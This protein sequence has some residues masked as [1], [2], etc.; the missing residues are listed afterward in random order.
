MGEEEYLDRLQSDT[1]PRT[2]Y[3]TMLA[4]FATASGLLALWAFLALALS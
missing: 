4:F 3:F 1:K 2:A